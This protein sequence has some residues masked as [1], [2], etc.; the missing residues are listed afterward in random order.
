MLY[1]DDITVS[2]NS[3]CCETQTIRL[4]IVS[5]IDS[6]GKQRSISK[7]NMYSTHLDDVKQFT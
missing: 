4:L 3:S 2:E 1:V 7:Q 6:T 5:P